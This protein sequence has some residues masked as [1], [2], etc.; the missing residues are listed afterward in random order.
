VTVADVHADLFRFLMAGRCGS[1]VNEWMGNRMT[2]RTLTKWESTLATAFSTIQKVIHQSIT[3]AV[4]RILLILTE[5]DSWASDISELDIVLDQVAIKR[6]VEISKGMAML[7]ETMRLDAE[8]EYAA[9]DEWC[10]W[11]R[12]GG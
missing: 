1:A 10:K 2:N 11:L 6:G 9:A 3:P 12:Y 8:T 5:L 7:V 4:E